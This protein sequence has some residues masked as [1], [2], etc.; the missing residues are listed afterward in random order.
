[1]RIEYRPGSGQGRRFF[2]NE[3]RRIALTPFR[4]SAVLTRHDPAGRGVSE[5]LCSTFQYVHAVPHAV[6]TATC[7]IFPFDMPS[8]LQLPRWHRVK[9]SGRGW[10]ARPGPGAGRRLLPGEGECHA[11]PELRDGCSRAGEKHPIPGVA[12]DNCTGSQSTRPCPMPQPVVRGISSG[13]LPIPSFARQTTEGAS[14]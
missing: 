6:N 3:P 8:V 7:S 9:D 2:P 5:N 1:M 13:N 11:G 4:S 14:G 10:G 12:V